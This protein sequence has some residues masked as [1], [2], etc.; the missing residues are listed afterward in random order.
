[1]PIRPR[2]A[3]GRTSKTRTPEPLTDDV[4]KNRNVGPAHRDS[5]EGRASAEPSPSAEITGAALSRREIP[6]FSPTREQRIAEAAYWRAERR[7]FAPDHE[8]DDWLEAERE[9]DE[10]S[11]RGQ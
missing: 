9:I 10:R 3:S 5:G 2:A 6:S 11:L 4:S 7:G 1:M 8:L